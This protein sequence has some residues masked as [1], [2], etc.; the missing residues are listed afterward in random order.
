VGFNI[1]RTLSFLSSQS[2]GVRHHRHQTRPMGESFLMRQALVRLSRRSSLIIMII[3]K[4]EA[5]SS[6]DFYQI[7]GK[8][9]DQSG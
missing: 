8:N 5:M 1:T 9:A 7:Q 4:I 3:A 6:P 2:A